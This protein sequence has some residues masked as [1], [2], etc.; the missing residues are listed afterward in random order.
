MIH[1]FLYHATTQ[2]Y[3]QS[4]P[5]QVLYHAT[6]QP[7]DQMEENK[8]NSISDIK[9]PK[10]ENKKVSAYPLKFRLHKQRQEHM[11]NSNSTKPTS[12]FSFWTLEK[13]NMKSHMV[14]TV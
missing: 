14:R 6:T 11:L 7:L 4:G 2:T 12:E 5:N 1:Y 9:E 10:A 8:P 3:N 13:Q